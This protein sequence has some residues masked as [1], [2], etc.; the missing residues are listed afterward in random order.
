VVRAPQNTHG[1]GQGAVNTPQN[2][3]GHSSTSGS[4]NTVTRPAA[5]NEQTQGNVHGHN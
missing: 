5:S 1:H 4:S 3:H 2:T